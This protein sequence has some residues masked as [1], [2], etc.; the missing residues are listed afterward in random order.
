[1][2]IG[3][4]NDLPK[5]HTVENIKKSLI[6]YIKEC[7]LSARAV[8]IFLDELKTHNIFIEIDANVHPEIDKLPVDFT[9]QDE[10]SSVYKIEYQ[11]AENFLHWFLDK[12]N[13]QILANEIINKTLVHPSF[14]FEKLINE[15]A[16]TCE[17]INN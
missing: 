7:K 8:E 14:A 17:F 12:E 16:N 13:V 15:T 11:Q 3:G 6:K 5:P 9:C 1:M 4:L 10:N 2:G